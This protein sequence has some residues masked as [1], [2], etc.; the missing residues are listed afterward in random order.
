M[1]KSTTI[2]FFLGK[3]TTIVVGSSV[4]DARTFQPYYSIIDL[5]T[6]LFYQLYQANADH[7]D[8][9]IDH[10]KL[11]TIY[12]IYKTLTQESKFLELLVTLK[13]W[14]LLIHIADK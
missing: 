3:S 5:K 1:Y 14:T 7:I 12:Q 2:V 9:L 6:Y 10:N 4:M 8:N 11:R 13:T